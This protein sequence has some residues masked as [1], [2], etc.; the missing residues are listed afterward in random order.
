MSGLAAMC[1]LFL[2]AKA[3]SVDS[4]MHTLLAGDL[5]ELHARDTELGEAVLRHHYQLFHNYDAVAAIM[6][7][8]R[9]LSGKLPQ[10]QQAGVLP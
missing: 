2:F 3:Q 8:M 5:R 6:Q 9:T 7:R 4:D 10:Y 1:L